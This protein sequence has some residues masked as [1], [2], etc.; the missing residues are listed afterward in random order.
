MTTSMN[1]EEDDLLDNTP[2]EEQKESKDP[3]S[4][5]QE[6]TDPAGDTNTSMEDDKPGRVDLTDEELPIPDLHDHRKVT[7]EDENRISLDD[8][9]NVKKEIWGRNKWSF[10]LI[11]A[12]AAVIAIYTLPSM[13]K[14]RH[15]IG[16]ARLSEEMKYADV[17]E[18]NIPESLPADIP[19]DEPAIQELPQDMED[20]LPVETVTV[21]APPEELTEPAQA[22]VEKEFY[23]Q[24]GT[25]RNPAY[26][27]STLTRLKPYYPDVYIVEKN[28]FH[29]IRIPDIG[30]KQEGSRIIDNIRKRFNLNSLLVLRKK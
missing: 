1:P 16:P 7:M 12:V 15:D 5:D 24:V 21:Q 11:I 4:S 17:D 9:F 14:D 29:V 20:Q 18:E 26:A 6:H 22:V 28:N 8:T 23:I 27:E 19:S 25:W 3:L 13:F 2:E 10:L 30:N